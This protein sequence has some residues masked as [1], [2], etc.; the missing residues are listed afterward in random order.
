MQ[1]ILVAQHARQRE[2]NL[3]SG[4]GD[5]LDVVVAELSQ[6]LNDALDEDLRHG[7]AGGDTDGLYAFEPCWVDFAGVIHQVGVVRHRFA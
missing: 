2:N 3:L 7:S 6:A 5:F 4:G 1:L